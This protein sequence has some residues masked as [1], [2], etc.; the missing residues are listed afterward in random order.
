MET[1]DRNAESVRRGDVAF[2]PRDV[3]ARSLLLVGIGVLVAGFVI[4]FAVLF[5]FDSFAARDQHRGLQP[6]TMVRSSEVR[7]PPEPRLQVDPAREM[8][9]LQREQ[10]GKLRG[11]DWADRQAGTVR[12]PIERAMLLLVERGLPAVPQGAAETNGQET[13]QGTVVNSNRN[14]AAEKKQ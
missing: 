6:S 11:Y 8:G 5:L 12:I 3:N 9:E 7:Q 13:R 10:A 1:N 14:Q 4:H 2:E